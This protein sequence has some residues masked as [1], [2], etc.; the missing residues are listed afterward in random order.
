MEDLKMET[1]GDLKKIINRIKLK[2]KSGKIISQ[3][4]SFI[5]DQ[6]LGLIPGASNAKT[7]FEFLKAAFEK[8]DTKKTQTW[9]DK[10]DIDDNMSAIIDDTVENGFLK[11]MADTIESEP[12]D[13]P[14]ESDFNMNAK[15]VGYLK[16]KYNQR[17]VTGI[18]ER[19][20]KYKLVKKVNEVEAKI[21]SSIV[22]ISKDLADQGSNFKQINTKDKMVQLFDAMVNKIKEN[23]PDFVGSSTFKQALVV[24]YNKYK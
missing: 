18:S 7:T 15:M 21:P 3:G 17:T 8:P 13:K 11:M 1:Y 12:D 14:L 22:T 19:K 10:L 16:D 20:M 9:L 2:Q 23:N 4:K 6:A 5:L 24:I